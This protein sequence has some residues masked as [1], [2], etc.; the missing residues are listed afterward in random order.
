MSKP[1]N[2]NRFDTKFYKIADIAKRTDNYYEFKLLDDCGDGYVKRYSYKK[3]LSIAIS[4]MT[5]HNDFTYTFHVENNF[6]EL[7]YIKKG[8]LEI[9]DADKK[10]YHQVNAGEYFFNV[11]EKINGQVRQP[12]G[13]TVTLAINIKPEFIHSLDE[14]TA[15]IT[16]RINRFRV[17]CPDCPVLIE[18]NLDIKILLDKMLYC[19]HDDETIHKLTFQSAVIELITHCLTR[20]VLV[21]AVEKM[22]ISLSSSDKRQLYLAQQILLDNMAKPPSV[23]SLSK[24]LYMNSFK[25]KVGFKALFSKTLYGYLRDMRLEKAK[26]LLKNTHLSISSIAL[27]IGYSNSS[28]F[29]TSFKSKY[30]IT[31]KQYRKQT[32]E[33]QQQSGKSP[34]RLHTGNHQHSPAEDH[35]QYR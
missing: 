18:S 19:P 9:Y 4:T 1:A 7:V 16:S 10:E 22:P 28:S 30:G 29:I 26:L 31:P 33:W 2:F 21:G 32:Y 3:G 13:E 23:E 6:L 15:D 17:N 5:L 14:T 8:H 20:V 24:H 35:W 34:L 27:Q 25:L 11:A 12:K